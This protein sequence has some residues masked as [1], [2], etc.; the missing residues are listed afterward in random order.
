[1]LFFMRLAKLFSK[2]ALEVCEG[3]QW[4]DFETRDDVT[5]QNTL[6]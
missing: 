6:K 1:M 2:T 3:Q 4:D 5:I